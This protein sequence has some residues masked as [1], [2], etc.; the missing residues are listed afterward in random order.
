MSTPAAWAPGQ[1]KQRRGTS[2]YDCLKGHQ[3]HSLN[4]VEDCVDLF[5]ELDLSDMTPK[6]RMSRRWIA[7]HVEHFIQ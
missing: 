3:H 2:R 1:I 4:E 6:L 5:F 7:K